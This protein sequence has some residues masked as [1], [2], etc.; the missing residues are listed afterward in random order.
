M[1]AL[2]RSWQLRTL[3][4]ELQPEVPG[5]KRTSHDFHEFPAGGPRGMVVADRSGAIVLANAQ[6]QEIFG[7]TH[8]ANEG[9]SLRFAKG[10]QRI[11]G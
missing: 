11:S 10:W 2:L 8:G 7:Y 6:A 4:V 5:Y 1:I 9:K 3:N